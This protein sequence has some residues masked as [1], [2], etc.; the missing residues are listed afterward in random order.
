M[1]PGLTVLPVTGTDIV[2]GTIGNSGCIMTMVSGMQ[3]PPSQSP[4]VITPRA[5]TRLCA[6]REA[7]AFYPD[8]SSF[9]SYLIL[10]ECRNIIYHF[11]IFEEINIYFREY[12]FAWEIFL[13]Q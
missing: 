7:V 13:I 5:R 11:F 6:R 12:L 9:Y 2:R 3:T 10:E 8:H 4:A 1:L